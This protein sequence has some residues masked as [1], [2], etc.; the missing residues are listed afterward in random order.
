ML[1][2]MIEILKKG[3]GWINWI[4]F[5]FRSR[6]TVQ[7]NLCQKLLFLHQL[8]QNMTTDCS[9]V[10]VRYMKIPSSEMLRTCCVHELFWMLK[11]KTI[12]VHNMFW[13]WKFHVLNSQ[14]NEQSFVI[15]WVSWY[16]NKWFLKRFTC[17]NFELDNFW[18]DNWCIPVM[19]M[20]NCCNHVE[21]CIHVLDSYYVHKH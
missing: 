21:Q 6:R 9:S 13:A 12:C 5:I 18:L 14:F 4:I 2:W 15:L 8:T 20:D 10:Q 7:V 11:Q 3:M 17:N 19:A 16:K 1:F